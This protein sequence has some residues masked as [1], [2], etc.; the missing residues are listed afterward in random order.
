MDL[1]ILSGT[2]RVSC[3]QKKHSSTHTYHG[4]QSSLICF[5]HL[6]RS[7]A[8]PLPVQFMCLTVFFHSLQVLFCLALAWHPPLHTFLHPI[9]VFFLRHIT[10]N[11]LV[12]HIPIWPFSSLLAEVPPCFPFL[13]VCMFS[14]TVG[15]CIHVVVSLVKHKLKV[16]VGLSK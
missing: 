3:Y 16:K 14:Y 7:M 9:I 4:H 6:L 10:W 8:S 15:L 2:T 5:L 1:W 13:Q 11:Y 12:C